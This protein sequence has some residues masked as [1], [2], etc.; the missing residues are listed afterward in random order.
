M[1]LDKVRQ[2]A[3]KLDKTNSGLRNAAKVD[4]ERFRKESANLQN[5]IS[6][7]SEKVGNLTGRLSELSAQHKD[8]S[9]RLKIAEK[10]L[11]APIN[12]LTPSGRRSQRD[13]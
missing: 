5:T 11:A 6:G 8:T 13:S 2:D 7:L 9:K 10:K 12:Q 1:E 3:I 4:H